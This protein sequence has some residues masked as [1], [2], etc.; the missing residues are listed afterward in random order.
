MARQRTHKQNMEFFKFIGMGV[1][2]LLIVAA[3]VTGVF[4]I[5]VSDAAQKFL[6][7]LMGGVLGYWTK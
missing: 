5:E 4:F 1:L 3:W 6:Y 7:G 2:S